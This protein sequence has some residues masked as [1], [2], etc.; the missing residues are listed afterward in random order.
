MDAK[1]RQLVLE[2][3]ASAHE[4]ACRSLRTDLELLPPEARRGVEQAMEEVRSCVHCQF[5]GTMQ[6]EA[7][8]ERITALVYGHSLAQA[9]QAMERYARTLNGLLRTAR[10]R[11]MDSGRHR[12]N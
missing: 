4:A 5:E 1:T 6:A 12:D 10:D 11:L 8:T 7:A 2:T 9:V 3:L